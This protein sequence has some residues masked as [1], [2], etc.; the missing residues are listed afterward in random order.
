MEP[1]RP[2]AWSDLAVAAVGACAALTGLLFVAVSINLARVLE[3]PDLPGRAART[4][5]LLVGLLAAGVCVLVPGQPVGALAAELGAVGLLLV[6]A[7]LVP[8]LRGG[9]SSGTSRRRLVAPVLLL[10]PS[11]ALAACAVSLLAGA[12]GGLY[13]LAVALVTGMAGASANAWVLLVEINR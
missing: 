3:F 2:E 10:V 1:Y 9:T 7:A 12:G 4:L 11:A 5:G 13:W 6:V 8:L